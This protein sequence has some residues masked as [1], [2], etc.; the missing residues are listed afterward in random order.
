MFLNFEQMSEIYNLCDYYECMGIKTTLTISNDAVSVKFNQ[1]GNAFVNDGFWN[2]TQGRKT[3]ITEYI[4]YLDAIK[5]EF[6][7]LTEEKN[8]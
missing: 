7:K 3:Y 8:A 6:L 5:K 4:E 2:G 1:E